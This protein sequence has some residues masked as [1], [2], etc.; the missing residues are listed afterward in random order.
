LDKPVLSALDQRYNDVSAH[1][2]LIGFLSKDIELSM[3]EAENKLIEK[4]QKIN[5]SI[6]RALGSEDGL[7][8]TAAFAYVCSLPPNQ[9]KLFY[10][11]LISEENKQ[12]QFLGTLALGCM[13][14]PH[15]EEAL[16]PLEKSDEP[17]IAMAVKL[18]FERRE[19]IENSESVRGI[20]D[21]LQAA[22][23]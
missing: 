20:L 23:D 16:Y 14:Y 2:Q 6:I 15:S 22:S 17:H 10:V 3:E 5:G 21:E 7:L 18:A 12:I 13:P 11:Q 19:G 8:A 1:P 4:S 9:V